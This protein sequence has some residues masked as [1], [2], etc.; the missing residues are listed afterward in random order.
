MKREVWSV[1]SGFFWVS[2]IGDTALGCPAGSPEDLT[3]AVTWLYAMLLSG[4]G[5]ERA[6]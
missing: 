6:G 1:R 5:N 4:D 3:S 2:F